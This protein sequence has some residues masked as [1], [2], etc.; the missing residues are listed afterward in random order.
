MKKEK[1]IIVGDRAL[2]IALL[3]F[4]LFAC[5][6]PP[7]PVTKPAEALEPVSWGAAA[8]TADDLQFKGLAVAARQ[9]LEYYKKLPA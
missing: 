1:N 8:L 4:S 7:L 3:L 2:I 6:R 9:S 5:A